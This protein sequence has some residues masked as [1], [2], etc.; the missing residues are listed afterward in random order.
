MSHDGWDREREMFLNEVT[1]E[2]RPGGKEAVDNSFAEG[3]FSWEASSSMQEMSQG[4]FGGLMVGTVCLMQLE[5]WLERKVMA[6]GRD[7]SKPKSL[8]CTGSFVNWWCAEINVNVSV[9]DHDHCC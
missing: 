4:Y 7:G 3:R 8:A 6:R 9:F 5:R 2:L 1:C